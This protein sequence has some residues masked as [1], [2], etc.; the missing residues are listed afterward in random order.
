[1]IIR[2]FC[3]SILLTGILIAGKA[4]AVEIETVVIG[5]P[6]NPPDHL[7][8][9]NNPDNL[10]FG[11]VPYVYRIGKYEVTNEQYVEFL[12]A[13]AVA[14]SFDLYNGL[15][16]SP[17]GGIDRTGVSGAF[18]YTTRPNMGNKPVNF[19]S[20]WDAA[21]FANWLHNGQPNESENPLATEYGAY[22]LGGVASPNNESILRNSG[23]RWFLPTENE[24]YKAAYFDPRVEA[25]GGPPGSDHYWTY[26]TK[27]DTPPVHAM[28]HSNGDI[29]NPGANLANYDDAAQWNGQLGNLTSVGTA[30]QL[31]ASYYGTFDQSGNINE[32]NETITTSG[33]FRGRRGG[34]WRASDVTMTASFRGHFYGVGG[35]DVG[36][37][38]RVA[39]FLVPEPPAA[40]VVLFS[41]VAIMW[42]RRCMR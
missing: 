5:D 25:S 26:A 27:S 28:A 17:R 31:S 34:S 35:E 7:S 6:G 22:S 42:R 38:F 33:P 13:V 15:M 20:F 40:V 24:W 37:G 12:N 1:M 3:F 9:F 2:W 11:S 19:V 4:W 41:V 30:G 14:D 23:A 18:S 32:W 10:R 21:R 29:S 16:A 8:T 36:G 39:M